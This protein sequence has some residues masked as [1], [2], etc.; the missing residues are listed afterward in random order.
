MRLDGKRIIVTGGGRGIGA[1]AITA[2]VR[3]GARVVGL[4]VLDDLGR[5]VA[6]KSTADGPGRARFHH[7]D[8]SDRASVTA[9]FD[10]A[11]GD[12]GGLD[13]LINC[14]G[15]ER[16]AAPEDIDDE[17]WDLVFAINVKGTFLTNRAAFRA[18]KAGG[19]HILNFG[20]D[21]GL[22]PYPIAGHYS[23]SKGAVHSWTRSAAAAW[24]QYNITV[25][26]VVPA[27]WTPMYDE[28]RA[29][30]DADELV[31]HDQMMAQ[32]V[33]IGG[34]LGNPDTDLG[35]VLVFLVSDDSRFITGQI[36]SV[37]GGAGNTR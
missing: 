16:L 18:L 13:S 28:H 23:A 1:A 26:S 8:V 3:E 32:V 29:Q 4:D 6:E 30:L 19:G 24:G 37:N 9:A 12:L 21:A 34:K 14:A 2:L 22:I 7:C 31:A 20:S 33:P 5:A 11:V 27:M 35:P 25:N 15:I 10:W 36:I 17:E